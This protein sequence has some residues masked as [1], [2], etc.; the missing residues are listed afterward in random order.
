MQE[1]DVT[2]KS[3]EES[4]QMAKDNSSAREK[5]AEVWVVL[6]SPIWIFGFV[7]VPSSC[8]GDIEQSLSS[9]FQSLLSQTLEQQLAA[10]KTG[11]EQ[12]R[13]EKV[14]EELSNFAAQLQELQ[15]QFVT[16]INVSPQE[17]SQ[18]PFQTSLNICSPHL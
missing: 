12:L 4:L 16:H 9:C 13:Q 18:K 15:A 6:Y 8:S 14:S 5:V 10:L 17:P 7:P 2:L 11:M 3:M 1:K